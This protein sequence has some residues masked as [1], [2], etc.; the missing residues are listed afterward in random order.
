MGSPAPSA[1]LV[2]DLSIIRAF[3]VARAPPRGLF[4]LREVRTLG[5]QFPRIAR[6][7]FAKPL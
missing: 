4:L 2:D 5:R 1:V 6:S 7:N 3:L